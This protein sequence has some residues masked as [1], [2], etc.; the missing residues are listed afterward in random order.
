LFVRQNG[1][2][3]A[4]IA[5]LEFI[6]T[7]RRFLEDVDAAFRRLKTGSRSEIRQLGISVYAQVG[8]QSPS[9]K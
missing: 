2:T 8:S 6:E 7:A 4:T 5:G 3:R 1:G 9:M